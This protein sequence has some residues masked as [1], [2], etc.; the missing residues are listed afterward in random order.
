MSFHDAV[1]AVVDGD[2]IA[3][4]ALLDKTPSLVGERAAAPHRATLLH[5][6]GANGVEAELQR[7]PKNAAAITRIL[8]EAGADADAAA[9]IYGAR[10][11]TLCMTVTS[12]HPCLAGVQADIVDALVDHGAR[13]EGLDGDGQPLGCAVLF[14]YI[15]AAERLVLRGARADNVIYAA[16]LGRADVVRVMLA[17]RTGTEGILRRNDA[18]EGRFSFPV[19]RAAD[20]YEVA[21]VVAAMHAR[22]ST[23]RVLLDGGVPVNATPFAGQTALHFAA[24]LGRVAIVD[25]LLARG[26]DPRIVDKQMN[27][28]AAEWARE[29]G[30]TELADKLSAG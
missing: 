24:Q 2:E 23:V 10:D 28:T 29:G 17:M 14:G 25:E 12:I 1:H 26:A 18:R 6:V 7:S 8:L 5:Y 27:Q 19:A 30:H 13:V 21:L 4:R 3:L 22:L 20:A 15:R 9:P 11:T 16:G